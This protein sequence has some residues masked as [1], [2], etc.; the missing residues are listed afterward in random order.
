MPPICQAVES[1]DSD[2][3]DARSTPSDSTVPLSPDHTL[4]HTTPTLIPSPRR[5]ARMTAR[6]LL[7]MSPDVS[8]SIAVVS[9][10]S[11]STF[12][13]R[14]RSS[15]KSLPSSSSSSDLPSQKHSR[16][17]SELVEDVEKAD[18]EEEDEE[19][20]EG[21]V[22]EDEGPAAGDEG[23]DMRVKSLGLGGDEVV[24]EG[25]QQAPSVVE[26]T[27]GEPL[28]LGYVALRRREITSR[29]GQTDAQRAALWHAISDMQMENRELQ[30]IDHRGKECTLDLA[31]IVDS[32]RRGQEP[33]GDV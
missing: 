3:S 27:V 21:L 9:A 20:K 14:F 8:A 2:T 19:V 12:L 25:Q 18:N 23:L 31:K 6:V 15:Y 29:K 5:T 10:I 11:D 7:A 1:E 30:V 22:V 26:T 32:I 24:P 13:K 33:R 16:G 17:T 28:G 4:T